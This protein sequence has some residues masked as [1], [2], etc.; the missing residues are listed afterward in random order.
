[1]NEGGP[2]EPGRDRGLGLNSER[3]VVV[4]CPV[5]NESW[6]I[7]EFLAA[8]SSFADHIII[9]DHGSTDNTV[10][11]ASQN[12]KVT[13][14]TSSQSG[15]EE[16]ARRNEL[17]TEARKFGL[18]NV[19]L[20]IDADE[21]LDPRFISGGGFD[22]IKTLPMGTRIFFPHFNLKPGGQSYWK[23]KIGATGF[24]DDG[25]LHS[26]FDKIHF[27]RIPSTSR[28]NRAPKAY[29]HKFGGLIHLQYLNWP[30]VLGKTRWYKAWEA[31]NNK[32]V[33]TLQIHRRYSH[34]ERIL[35]RKSDTTPKEWVE[36][37][38]QVKL[39][40]AV[41]R[42]GIQNRNWWD[43]EADDLVAELP[44]Q[45]QINLGLSPA[46]GREPKKFLKPT[47]YESRLTG[48]LAKTRALE[49]ASD[50]LLPRLGLRILDSAFDALTM[51]LRT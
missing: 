51:S 36:L 9:G 22:E 26:K 43:D 29:S 3:K 6:I 1:M 25:S 35:G 5:K 16:A 12:T 32:E 15:F 46:D 33:T 41:A 47:D 27:P 19:V 37:F 31:V 8:A 34:I 10:Q 38:E 18:G 50:S 4:V 2:G 20:S 7:Q 40:E 44:V 39:E 23:S 48:Y 11:L 17:L 45:R 49:E 42:S 24:I 14:I 13:L 28:S 30:R 21:M